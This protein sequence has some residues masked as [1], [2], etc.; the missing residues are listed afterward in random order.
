[1]SETNKLKASFIMSLFSVF[2]LFQDVVM[3]AIN[4]SLPGCAL[5]AVVQNAYRMGGPV[6]SLSYSLPLQVL[7]PR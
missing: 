5:P 3:Q 1:M 2:V 6:N 7:Q 4:E